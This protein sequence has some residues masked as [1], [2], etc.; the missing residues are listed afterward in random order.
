[1]NRRRLRL[2]TEAGR[3]LGYQRL[4]SRR[5]RGFVT[6][7]QGRQPR[8]WARHRLNSPKW[9]YYPD[10]ITVRLILGRLDRKHAEEGGGQVRTICWLARAMGV[11]RTCS[12]I[13][14]HADSAGARG[15][16]YIVLSS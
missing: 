13:H 16:S 4:R 15:V 5:Q 10:N 6:G 8:I 14:E 9:P 3:Q 1:L 11:V 7:L 12:E 2:Q